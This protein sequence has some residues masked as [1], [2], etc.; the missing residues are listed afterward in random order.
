MQ[1]GWVTSCALC[2]LTHSTSHLGTSQTTLEEN[3]DF[4]SNPGGATVTASHQ[5][6]QKP[7]RD[8]TFIETD[9]N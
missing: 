1:R 6:A 9:R 2:Q 5:T 8:L 4:S 7:A 3:A